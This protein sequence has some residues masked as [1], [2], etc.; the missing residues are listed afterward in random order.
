MPGIALAWLEGF[1]DTTLM[2]A[3]RK[4]IGG[5]QSRKLSSSLVSTATPSYMCP[6]KFVWASLLNRLIG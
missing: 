3:I 4:V 1:F 5:L 2:Q 6:T